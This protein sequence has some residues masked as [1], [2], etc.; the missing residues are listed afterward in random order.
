M[1]P[2]TRPGT[3][4]VT[5]RRGNSPAPNNRPQ[6]R[7]NQRASEFARPP[8]YISRARSSEIGHLGT[9]PPSNTSPRSSSHQTSSPDA[10][11]LQRRTT[12]TPPGPRSVTPVEPSVT[13]ENRPRGIMQCV[14]W[15]EVGRPEDVEVCATALAIWAASACCNHERLPVLR[16]AGRDALCRCGRLAIALATGS[17]E[18]RAPRMQLRLHHSGLATK[19]AT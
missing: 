12:P 16:G 8:T 5:Q 13:S 17:G 14:A 11:R 18:P 3:S 2:D 9:C 10:R 4:S 19:V 6:N 7:A 15:A 1:S